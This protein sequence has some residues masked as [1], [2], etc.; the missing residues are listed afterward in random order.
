LYYSQVV[1]RQGDEE[2]S[3]FRDKLYER[4]VSQQRS[5]GSWQGNISP[6]YVTSCNLIIL[7]LDRAYLPIYQR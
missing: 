7:Q 2:W 4:I 5:D 1:Y 6:V 3:P